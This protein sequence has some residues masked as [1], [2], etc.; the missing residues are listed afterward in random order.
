MVFLLFEVQYKKAP[1]SESIT[2][3]TQSNTLTIPEVLSTEAPIHRHTF[4]LLV[5]PHSTA[6]DN[7]PP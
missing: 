5:T 2:K 3:L 7:V 1:V 4:S 6:V